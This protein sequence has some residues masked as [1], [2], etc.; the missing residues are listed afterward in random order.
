MDFRL[1]G[2]ISELTDQSGS[3]VLRGVGEGNYMLRASRPNEPRNFMTEGVGAAAGD[4]A[5]KIVLP[6]EGGVKGRVLL[7]DGTPPSLFTLGVAMAPPTPFASADGSFTLADL[8]PGTVRITIAGPS[9]APRNLNLTIEAGKVQDLG[10]ITVA[11]GRKIIGTVSDAA[12]RPAPG[13]TV[14]AARR[15]GG[16]GGSVSTAGMGFGPGGGEETRTATSDERGEFALYGVPPHD[17]AIMADDET[18]GRSAVQLVPGSSQD[19]RV[20]LTLSPP[21]AIEGLVTRDGK[22]VESVGVNV[23]ARSAPM[24]NFVV[25]TGPDGRFRFDRLAADSD[26]VQAIGGGNPMTGMQFHTRTATVVSGKVATVNIEITSGATVV[27]QPTLAGGG[28]VRIGMVRAT[29]GAVAATTARDFNLEVA[30]KGEP[31]SSLSVA[32]LGNPARIADVPPG[33][34]SVCVIPLPAEVRGMRPSFEYIEREGDNLPVYCSAAH[35]SGTGEIP[36]TI[37]VPKLP[38][39]VPPPPEEGK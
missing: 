22:P 12:G 8:P 10:T 29:M 5:V 4:A 24:T 9:F 17:V 13:A 21:G 20:Q 7:A 14:Y 6:E 3:F 33:D 30:R 27:A 2:G 38:V 28:M 32:I 35:V 18:L 31:F 15:L 11:A 39:Y 36:V 16:T 25:A 26:L 23:S 34:V 37:I 1:R 19:S